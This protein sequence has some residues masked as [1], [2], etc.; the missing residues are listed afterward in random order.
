MRSAKFFI[1]NGNI[2]MLL[3]ILIVVAVIIGTFAYIMSQT[4]MPTPKELDLVDS[5][6]QKYKNE[7]ESVLKMHKKEVSTVDT[8]MEEELSAMVR[9]AAIQPPTIDLSIEELPLIGSSDTMT[10]SS[11]SL[12]AI[13]P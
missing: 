11:I 8:S 9:H 3:W 12:T 13:D 6:M 2:K 1:F 5:R 10:G 4:G 7:I